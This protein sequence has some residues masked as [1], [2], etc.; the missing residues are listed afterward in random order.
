MVTSRTVPVNFHAVSDDRVLSNRYLEK[1]VTVHYP[2]Y[3]SIAYFKR[4]QVLFAGIT[5]FQ[6]TF[7]QSVM[8]E[9]STIGI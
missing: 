1:V 4:V 2:I 8:I 9:S 7:M 5:G 3:S 6:S